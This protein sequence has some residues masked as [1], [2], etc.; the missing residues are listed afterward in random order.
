MQSHTAHRGA[1]PDEPSFAE[2]FTPKLVTSLREGYDLRRLVADLIA[3]LTVAIVALPLSMG[4]SIAAGVGPERGLFT[5]IVGGIIIS[6]LGG[7]RFQIGGPAAAFIVIVYG[8]VDKHG[9]DGLALATFMAGAMLVAIGYLRLGTYIKYI[10]YPVT[11]GF[12]AGIGVTI[13]VSQIAEIFG[14]TVAKMPGEFIE[15]IETLWHAAPSVNLQTLVLSL[16]AIG[17]IL[18]LR[19]VRPRWPGLLF[20]VILG[21]V[22]AAAFHLDVTTVGSRFGSIPRALPSPSL[23]DLSLAKIQAVFPSAVTIALLAGIESLLSAVVADGMTGRRHR[24][25]CELVAQGFANMA[26]P[27]FGGI[28]VTGT[29]AR[30]ATNIRSGSTGPMS[31]ILHAVFVALMM[32]L[33]APWVVYVPLAVLAAILVIVAWNMMEMH[34]IVRFLRFSSWGDRLVLLATLG[35]TVFFDLMLGIEVGVVM[36]AFLFMHH[37]AEAVEVQS[38]GHATLIDRDQPDD[39][40]HPFAKPT[41]PDDVLVYRISGPFFFGAASQVSTAM[42]RTTGRPR[43]LIFDFSGV[44]LMDSTGA[45]T[46]RGIIEDAQKRDTRVVLAG[47]SYPVR[48]SLVRFG[49]HRPHV[50]VFTAPSVEAA[51]SRN[52]A[53]GELAD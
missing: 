15:K 39:T 36:A 19:K 51:L 24:S 29:I 14:L 48:R 35:V 8:I 23:P 17:F 16:A 7:S 3:G 41:I 38:P 20:A 44:P 10:P 53:T 9:Y 32:L 37:M 26:S 31:G 43:L 47:M 12:T 5:A 50:N 45:A 49:I 42:A 21:A 52:D 27:L 34:V 30:T 25:N 18:T 6:A 2:L 40:A 13:F 22:I 1:S 4:I 28:P 11:I 33:F 46:L